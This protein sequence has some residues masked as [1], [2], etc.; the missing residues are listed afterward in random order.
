MPS[1]YA[2]GRSEVN[3]LSHEVRHTVNQHQDK[4]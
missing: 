2:T 1:A 4:S 3:D